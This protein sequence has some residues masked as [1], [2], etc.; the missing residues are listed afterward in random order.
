MTFRLEIHNK[1]NILPL[2]KHGKRQQE[3][4]LLDKP[5]YEPSGASICVGNSL[6][7]SNS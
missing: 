1:E 3:D 5:D 6:K 7:I 2:K 4:K